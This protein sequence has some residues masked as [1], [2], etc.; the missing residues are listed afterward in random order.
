MRASLQGA[1]RLAVMDLRLVYL[2]SLFESY[3]RGNLGASR[4]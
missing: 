1:R 2:C 4:K 3:D